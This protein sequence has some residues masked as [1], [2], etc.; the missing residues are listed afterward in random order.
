M[1]LLYGRA[2]RL[3]ALFGGFRPGQWPSPPPTRRPAGSTRPRRRRTRRGRRRRSRRRR[4]CPSTASARATSSPRCGASLHSRSVSRTTLRGPISDMRR[5]VQHHS[6]A[7]HHPSHSPSRR[8]PPAAEAQHHPPL[9]WWVSPPHPTTPPRHHLPAL[10]GGGGARYISAQ[11][12]GYLEQD[13]W[14]KY[15]KNANTRAADLCAT[16]CLRLRLSVPLSLCLRLYFAVSASF[17]ASPSHPR[18]DRCASESP[19]RARHRS[20][21]GSNKVLFLWRTENP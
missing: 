20:E 18:R 17:S 15:A 14:R 19:R 21:G 7:P 8:S 16:A 6:V 5:S 11:L 10:T 13:C 4:G 12:V 1:G 9:E 3:T 2:G